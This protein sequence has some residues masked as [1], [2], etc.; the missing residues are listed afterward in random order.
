MIGNFW[1]P[2]SPMSWRDTVHTRR[3]ISSF[4]F[5]L[6][7]IS[8]LLTCSAY[9]IV[10]GD[11]K[12]WKNHYYSKKTAKSIST[13]DIRIIVVFCV[14]LNQIWLR[15]E[16]WRERGREVWYWMMRKYH[17]YGQCTWLM[18]NL[19]LREIIIK[20]NYTRFPETCQAEREQSNSVY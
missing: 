4:P 10:K 1:I 5:L 15:G 20:T 13:N 18:I 11:S 16:G 12:T 2:S 17:R 3:N 9:G 6:C 19:A 8:S 7:R 14:F